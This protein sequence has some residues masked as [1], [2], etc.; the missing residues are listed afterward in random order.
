MKNLL[1]K[2]ERLCEKAYY[3][4]LGL[5][6]V[7]NINMLNKYLVC[8]VENDFVAFSKTL[9]FKKADHKTLKPLY[10]VKRYT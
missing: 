6:K 9:G 7:F 4:F 5:S 8:V 10:Q 3:F 1:K 2:F